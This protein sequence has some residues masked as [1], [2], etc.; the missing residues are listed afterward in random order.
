[1]RGDF[2]GLKYG[3]VRK[4]D[5]L[6]VK[7]V[8]DG[9]R[10]ITLCYGPEPMERL[11]ADAEIMARSL[12]GGA[13]LRVY[14]NDEEALTAVPTWC[15]QHGYVLLLARKEEPREGDQLP[16]GCYRFDIA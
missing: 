12:A 5:F 2:L 11:L 16:F 6:G 13:V 3:R 8:H 4:Y 7:R 9:K 14:T 1:M 10:A 15:A